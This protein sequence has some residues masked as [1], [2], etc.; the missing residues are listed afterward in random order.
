MGM[1]EHYHP[2][3]AIVVDGQS[4]DVPAGIGVDPQTGRMSAVHTHTPDGVIHIEAAHPGQEFTLG[5][6][7]TEWNVKLG[8][9][10]LGSLIAH[11][12]TIVVTVN[13]A[14]WTG[15]PALLQLI[16]SSGCQ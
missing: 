14:T 16:C 5:Q 11:R 6:L 3:L 13:G 2:E 8:P 4:I 1:A 12:G 15:N 9:S 10:Q 7:F